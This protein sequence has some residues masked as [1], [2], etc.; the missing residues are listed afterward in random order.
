MPVIGVGGGTASGKT[1]VCKLFE[2]WGAHIIDADQI[3]KQVVDR[4]P[5]L[6]K[7]LALTFGEGILNHDTSLNRRELGKIV[8]QDQTA[9]KKLNDIVHPALLA[10]LTEHVKHWQGKE[11]KS[12]IVID[13]ALLLEWDLQSL[14]DALVVVKA[15]K[16]IRR[17]R[18]VKHVGLTPEE[19]SDRIEAQSIF[20]A[21]SSSAD[22]G[23]TNNST[24]D[25]LEQQAQLVWKEILQNSESKIQNSK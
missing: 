25:E 17:E 21:K 6:Q 5:G 22:Y 9:R 23:I 18:L 16:E 13:A 15:D 7:Q 14:L 20:E 19:A 12:V 11:P 3:G 4:N 24:L 2:K 10:E 8:F 1:T